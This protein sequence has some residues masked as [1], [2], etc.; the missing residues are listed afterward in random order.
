MHKFCTKTTEIKAP[1]FSLKNNLISIFLSFFFCLTKKRNKKS[2][3]LDTIQ[4]KIIVPSL[5]YSKIS[6]FTSNSLRLIIPEKRILFNVSSLQFLRLICLRLNFNFRM[7]NYLSH[8]PITFGITLI[9]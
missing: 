5:K 7:K 6:Q 8:I 9:T 1:L 2:Q 3:E 4:S